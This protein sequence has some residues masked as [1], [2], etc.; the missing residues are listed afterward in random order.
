MN[1]RVIG[2]D[3]SDSQLES[4]RKLGADLTFNPTSNPDYVAEIF[5]KTGGA[6]GAIVLSASNAAYKNADA[7]LR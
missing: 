6:H 7:I 1:L 4:G 5:H 2:I 3:I